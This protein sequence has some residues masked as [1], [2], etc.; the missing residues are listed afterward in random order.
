[1]DRNS[2]K[3]EAVRVIRLPPY[4]YLHVLDTNCNVTRV[5][6]GPQT[7]TRQE[8]EKIVAGPNPMIIVP[9]QHY[10]VIEN[11][12]VHDENGMYIIYQLILLH[13]IDQCKDSN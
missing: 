11:P 2:P 3:S 8:H 1:M 10:V 12:V 5:L 9:P 7:Y 6:A 13:A 4:Q